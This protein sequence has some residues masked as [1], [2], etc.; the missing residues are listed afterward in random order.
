MMQRLKPLFEENRAGKN[1]RWIFRTVI[2]CLKQIC[3]NQVKIKGVTLHQKPKSRSKTTN[4]FT[5]AKSY[6]M[7]IHLKFNK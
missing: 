1:R 4:Y 3:L 6:D 7:A 5:F 2:D